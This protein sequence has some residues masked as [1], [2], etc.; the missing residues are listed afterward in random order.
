MGGNVARRLLADKGF[1]V[2]IGYV[3]T[4]YSGTTKGDVDGKPVELKDGQREMFF[5]VGDWKGAGKTEEEWKKVVADT[6]DAVATGKIKIQMDEVSRS[7]VGL[8]GVYEAQARMREGKNT[9]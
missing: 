2:Q 9:G 4:D 1:L 8:A 7:F 5:F 3:G 6:I